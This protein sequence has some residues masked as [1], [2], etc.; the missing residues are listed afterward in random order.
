[1]KF[2]IIFSIFCISSLS[3]N[4]FAQYKSEFL[5]D[6]QTQREIQ[7]VWRHLAEFTASCLADE[8]D[9][10]APEVNKVVQKLKTYL[11]A[12]YSIH[13]KDWESLLVFVSENE[14][15][16]LFQD[17]E[18][19]THRLAVTE[20]KQYSKVYINKDRME[21]PLE[22]W[23]GILVHEAVHHLG[24][25][26]DQSRLPDQVGS[27]IT[28]HFLNQIQSSS[29]EQFN[30]PKSKSI[31]F[32]SKAP[33][34]ASFTLISFGEKTTDLSWGSTQFFPMCATHETIVKQ[35]VTAPSWQVNQ[36]QQKKGIVRIRGGGY[37]K[38]NCQSR[39]NAKVRT[40]T[41]AMSASFSLQYPAPL[42]LSLWQQETPEL[43]WLES[44]YG[45]GSEN[46][47]ILGTAQTFVI[48]SHEQNQ[49]K[50]KAGDLWKSSLVLR[51]MDDFV[52]E[53][54]QMHVAGTQYAYLSMD[55][56]IGANSFD[57]CT[58]KN[59]GP[60]LWQVEGELTLP[61]GIRADQY[62]VPVVF[63]RN[64]SGDRS[65]IPNIPQFVQVEGAANKVVPTIKSISF[66]D[67]KPAASLGTLSP[68]NSVQIK[69][70]QSFT[71]SFT[72]EGIE[73]TQD[74][75]FDVAVWYLMTEEFGIA[76]GTG[77]N[78]SWPEV[79]KKTTFTKTDKGTLIEMTFVLPSQLS[80]VQVA[81]IKMKRFYVRTPDFSWVE[82]E[83][84]GMHDYMV[85]NQ[86]YA[87]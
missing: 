84:P 22:T 36:I 24:Y 33:M 77:S 26:D 17:T 35:Y 52:P 65:A 41:I 54:C 50:L 45:L 66:G 27:A 38:A 44:E 14:M 47:Q 40:N 23:V 18:I 6:T 80:G 76:N 21:L 61:V 15:A 25:T 59:I 58:L 56:L 53:T 75:W 30:L 78:I 70:N 57:K 39:L 79:V 64:S 8:K 67:L 60:R 13:S 9:C 19:E 43:L 63:L 68:T 16:H 62:Y 11:P 28:K 48:L 7:W 42:N 46:L 34:Q 2:F 5:G 12:A 20:L 86:E 55:G 10:Q 83:I 3:Q 82:I 85:I 4:S 69:A 73:P 81:A 32:N 74:V 29:L 37:F 31:T 1:M 51:S 49:M 71:V 87:N 72:V